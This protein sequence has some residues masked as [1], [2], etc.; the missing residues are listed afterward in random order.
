M[1]FRIPFHWLPSSWGLK[2][3]AYEEAEACYYLSGEERERRIAEI[4]CKN[5]PVALNREYIRLNVI[6][7]RITAHER[8][9]QLKELEL[10]R[11]LTSAERADIDLQHGRITDYEHARRKVIWEVVGDDFS[12]HSPKNIPLEVALVDLDLKFNKIT[13]IQA[14]KAKATLLDEPWVGIVNQDFDLEDGVEGLKIEF[15]WNAQWIEYLKL[16]GYSG[17]DEESIVEQWFNHLCRSV[18]LEQSAVWDM[19]PKNDST[20]DA[21]AS[22]GVRVLGVT[23]GT[24]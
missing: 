2:G 21:M 9:V 1:S 18:V 16:N 13:K 10:G 11:V 6:Y 14:D 24:K 8:D 20:A 17:N 3:S 19:A 22:P 5:D 4:R 23:G 12:E 7:G 15:D